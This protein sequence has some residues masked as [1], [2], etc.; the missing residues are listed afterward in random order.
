MV[1]GILG[2]D[3]I[4]PSSGVSKFLR[5]M[6]PPSS[7]LKYIGSGIGWVIWIRYKEIVQSDTK[8]GVMEKNFMIE[9]NGVFYENSVSIL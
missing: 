6:L 3:T 8:R 1:T 2:F 7:G 9:K 4:W 5:N